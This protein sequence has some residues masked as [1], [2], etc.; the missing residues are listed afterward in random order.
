MQHHTLMV[1]L[2]VCE[3]AVASLAIELVS[4]IT[5]SAL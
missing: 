4:R 2:G 5:S 1:E 3:T